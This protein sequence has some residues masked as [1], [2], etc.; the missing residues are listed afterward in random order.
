[1]GNFGEWGYTYGLASVDQIRS[2]PPHSIL[3]NI[4]YEVRQ[5]QADKKPQDGDMHFVK[6][7]SRDHHPSNQNAEGNSAR[8]YQKPSHRDAFY[9]CV[10]E[11]YRPCVEGEHA[12]ERLREE[13]HEDV[14]GD[15]D[16]QAKVIRGIGAL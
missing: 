4:R 13:H 14:E 3:Y 10:R 5:Y 1:L 15:E 7:G 9:F 2:G 8:I 6:T 12:M 16:G 11:L